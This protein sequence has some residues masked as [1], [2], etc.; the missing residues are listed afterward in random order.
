MVLS[1]EQNPLGPLVSRLEPALRPS[2]TILTGRFVTLEPLH[3]S[4]ADAL[5]EVLGGPHRASLSDY[6]FHGAF[7]DLHE[8]HDHVAQNA[9]S[10][11]PVF[12]AICANRRPGI[13]LGWISYL[14]IEPNHLCLE[15]GHL[16]FSKELQRTPE[17]TEAVY[18][19]VRHAF[20]ALG[21]RRVEWKLNN[22]NAPSHRAASRY[23]FTFEGVFRKHL[24][25]KGRSRDTAWYSI[26][27]D[28][29]PAVEKAFSGWLAE[30]NFDA[31]GMQKKKLQD[32]RRTE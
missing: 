19:M 20:E 24:V 16:L 31:N 32:F 10:T 14:R 25:V 22:L 28:E 2:P 18:L 30:N 27:D 11:D 13:P 6:M 8:F 12:F 9:A 5:F 3:T 17:S 21:Y 15:I 7:L 4:H 29:W 26:V 1:T 23:G